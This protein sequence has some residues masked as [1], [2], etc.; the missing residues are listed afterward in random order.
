[1]RVVSIHGRGSNLNAHHIQ[2]R[3]QKSLK[4]GQKCLAKLLS[5]LDGFNELYIGNILTDVCVQTYDHQKLHAH[6]V[7]LAVNSEYF[8]QYFTNADTGVVYFDD[9]M[10]Q[11]ANLEKVINYFYSNQ[12]NVEVDPKG[13]L[14]ISEFLKLDDVSEA[15]RLQ[16]LKSLS[17]NGFLSTWNYFASN[18]NTTWEKQLLKKLVRMM[19]GVVSSSDFLDVTAKQLQTLLEVAVR[20]KTCSESLLL[21]GILRWAHFCPEARKQHLPQLL[22][23]VDSVHL[24]SSFL[25]RKLFNYQKILTTYPEVT[26]DFVRS[27]CRK[28]SPKQDYFVLSHISPPNTISITRH[29]VLGDEA[30]GSTE[31]WIINEIPHFRRNVM[32]S[33]GNCLYIITP[34]SICVLDLIENDW[35]YLHYVCHYFNSTNAIVGAAN[36]ALYI[37][38]KNQVMEFCLPESF[39]GW[40][41]TEPLPLTPQDPVIVNVDDTLHIIGADFVVQ[42]LDR[43]DQRWKIVSRNQMLGNTHFNNQTP[44]ASAAVSQH[45]VYLYRAN[46]D[47]LFKISL[48]EYNILYH[49]LPKRRNASCIR[50]MSVIE[51]GSCGGFNVFTVKLVGDDGNVLSYV[52]ENYCWSQ[53]FCYDPPASMA[54][55]TETPYQ[56]ESDGS[57]STV[58]FGLVASLRVG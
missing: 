34:E 32:C 43:M 38:R 45:T 18:T 40:V 15:C 17:S 13:I 21:T 7:V 2:A 51:G 52:G 31:E 27:I 37:M 11:F 14:Y 57:K 1:M 3:R 5:T 42:Y 56:T 23:Y 36:G 10:V 47:V 6:K 54:T 46:I 53:D 12:L 9:T 20:K 8:Y 39:S 44:F 28:R 25:A 22:S 29:P 35:T 49:M 55:W 50:C 30:V 24:P 16:M 33:Y 41:P 19:K 4:P 58:D 26:K 48:P